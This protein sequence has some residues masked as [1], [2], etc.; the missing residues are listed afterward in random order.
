MQHAEAMRADESGLTGAKQRLI[1]EFVYAA[2]SWDIERHVITHL[3]NGSQ[4]NNP[5][6]VAT[7]LA[8]DAVQLYERLY[9]S[10]G[11]AESRIKEAQLDLF[12]IRASCH[13]F[14]ANQLRLLLVAGLH[15]NAAPERTRPEGQRGWSAHLGHDP[16][17]LAEDR[18]GHLAQH[19]TRACPAG[20]APSA[21]QRLPQCRT[22]LMENFHDHPCS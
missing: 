10:R 12:G 4:G 1:D 22:G 8:G 21:A 16:R 15:I 7:D 19:E 17:A 20:F 13:R 6:F 9:C 5:R 18:C 11:E 2:D 3:E 14:A